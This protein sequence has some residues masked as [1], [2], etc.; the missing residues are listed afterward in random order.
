MPCSSESQVSIEASQRA[1]SIDVITGWLFFALLCA[2]SCLIFDSSDL[3]FRVTSALVLVLAAAYALFAKR[4]WTW[5]LAFLCPLLMSLYGMGQTL[6]SDQNIVFNGVDKSLYW[7]TAA[8][9]GFL[10][11]QLFQARTIARHFRAA[12]AI[13]AS[14]EALLSVLEQAAHTGKFFGLIPSGYGSVYGTFNYYNS[15]SQV[16][17]L[18]LPIT[19]WEGI[20]HRRIKFPFLLLA[21]LEIGAVVSSTSRAG[22]I[23][24]YC[25][26]L[27][28]LALAWFRRRE[29]MSLT[30][31]GLALA[32]SLG[33]T[34]VAGFQHVVE[35]LRAPD[36]LANRSLLNKSSIAMI[37][38]R[39][40]TG[41]GLGSYVPVYRMFALYDDGTWVNQAH[42]DYL[43]WAAEGG[44]PY[45]CIMLVLI[46]WTF[47][48]AVRAIWG[49][50]VLALCVHALV[51]YPF[52]H[53]S[54]CGW[55]F[56]LAGMLTSSR[57]DETE[58]RARHRQFAAREQSRLSPG[59]RTA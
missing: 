39:P 48:P 1:S 13:F 21:A 42:N 19:L 23:L 47:R 10:A 7:F 51:D 4:R 57:L 36:Q 33:F 17:E 2:F 16:V 45:A 46:V 3:S 31:L 12:I 24:V 35:K 54:V 8:M 52:A 53:L 18:A 11:A 26:L 29:S 15:F 32:L 49:I 22:T 56:A 44:I 37:E 58:P 55:Y 20:G 50:G 5:S 28:V 43:E 27:G 34:Y 9:I 38:A 6:W 41:W 25:E 59:P 40:L 14:F 30:V